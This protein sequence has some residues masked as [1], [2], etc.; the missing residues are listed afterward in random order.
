M[1]DLEAQ[2]RSILGAVQIGI[3]A[4]VFCRVGAAQAAFARVHAALEV[5]GG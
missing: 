2:P 1:R 3:V 5:V 4:V